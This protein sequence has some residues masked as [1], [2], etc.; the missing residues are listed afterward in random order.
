MFFV[1]ILKSLKDKDLYIGYTSNLRK[2]FAEHNSGLSRSTKSRAPLH[3]VYYEAYASQTEAKHRE[4]NLKLHG[5][6]RLQLLR[7]IRQSLKT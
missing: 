6:A 1:Y 3:L 5:R 7:R 2:R 4:E